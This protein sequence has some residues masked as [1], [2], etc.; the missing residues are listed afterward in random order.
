[1]FDTYDLPEIIT[2]ILGVV[3]LTVPLALWLFKKFSEKWLEAKFQEQLDAIRHQNNKELVELKNGLDISKN[4]SQLVQTKQLQIYPQFWELLSQAHSSA[5]YFFHQIREHADL[6][7]MTHSELRE[8]L[9]VQNIT[10]RQIDNILKLA[11]SERNRTYGL[12][13]ETHNAFHAEQKLTEVRD[14]LRTNSIF[15]DKEFVKNSE[16]LLKYFW[17]IIDETKWHLQERDNLRRKELRVLISDKVT[18][19]S[20]LIK[21]HI[22]SFLKV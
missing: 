8:F 12:L 1:M 19:L 5:L 15:M 16:E 13:I 7:L 6:S 22:A 14:Y 4:K 21:N 11:K 18:P 3:V 2:T 10:K 9:L 17:E 20:D